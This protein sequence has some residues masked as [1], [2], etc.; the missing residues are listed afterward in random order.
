MTT[1]LL[2]S[3]DVHGLAISPSSDGEKR[4]TQAT[5]DRNFSAESKKRSKRKA[6]KAN[7]QGQGSQVPVVSP[8]ILSLG[9]CGPMPA[10]ST[11]SPR[12]NVGSPS[13]SPP[14]TYAEPTKAVENL[15]QEIEKLRQE[16]KEANR[17]MKGLK[18]SHSRLEEEI[19]TWKQ[20]CE[21]FSEV[22]KDHRNK[23]E[24]MI[25]SRLSSFFDKVEQ[26]KEKEGRDKEE[27]KKEGEVK[28][29]KEKQRRWKDG[30]AEEEKVK[31]S[32]QKEWKEKRG[33][34]EVREEERGKAEEAKLKAKQDKS[35]KCCF[36]QIQN[37]RQHEKAKEE[38][39]KTWWNRLQIK[40]VGK[41][42]TQLPT[43]QI[44]L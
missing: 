27:K 24:G 11:T 1:S 14:L 2:N 31:K 5:D 7:T 40:T 42:A 10:P 18:E 30:K 15:R 23:V 28:G 41:L 6:K 29:R 25:N 4:S 26:G 44:Y 3:Q 8:E 12:S 17:L 34:E 38:R 36:E 43:C 32:K 21:E 22:I 9:Y 35:Q 39:R 16:L 37:Y 33:K 13:V 19:E 20:K